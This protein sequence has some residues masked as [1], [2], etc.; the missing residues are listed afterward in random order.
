MA[1]IQQNRSESE[2]VLRDAALRTAPQHEGRLW[3]LNP[4]HAEERREAARLEARSSA[5]ART[6][7]WINLARRSV[8]LS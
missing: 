1:Q 5:D 7:F 6:F 2:R 3:D 4:P 8:A